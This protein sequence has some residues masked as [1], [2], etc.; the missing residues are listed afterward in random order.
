MNKSGDK[1]Y[2]HV[3]PEPFGRRQ[4]NEFCAL[5]FVHVHKIHIHLLH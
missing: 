4:K 3:H 5:Q 1:R 2:F